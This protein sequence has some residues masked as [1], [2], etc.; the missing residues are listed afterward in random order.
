MYG[1]SGVAPQPIFFC[2]KVFRIGSKQRQ[3]LFYSIRPEY[4]AEYLFKMVGAKDT[5]RK[6]ARFKHTSNIPLVY[7]W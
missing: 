2:D 3:F 4:C 5:S 6:W 7:R 1:R